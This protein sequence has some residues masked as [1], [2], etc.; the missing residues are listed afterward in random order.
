MSAEP[1][2]DLKPETLTISFGYDPATALGAAKP[3]LYATTTFTYRS[4]QQAKDIHR[5][6]FDGAPAPDGGEAFIY[7]RLNHPNLAMIERRLAVLDRGEESAV[8]GSGMAAIGG[9]MLCLAK[10]GE[11]LAYNRPTYSGTDWMLF[12]HL[13]RFGVTPIGFSDATS[14][15]SLLEACETALAKGPLS[16]IMLESPANPTAAVADIAMTAR[17]AEAIGQRTGRRPLISVDNTFLG[18]FLQTPLALGA[19]LCITS[20]TKYCA[21][22]SDLLAGG[23]SGSKALIERL[24]QQRT[25]FGSALNA[26][27]AWLL[28]RSFETL[29]L[30][31]ERACQNAQAIAQ[32]LKDHPKVAGV[33]YLGFLEGA[34][35]AV[36]DRQ[37]RGFGSTFSFVVK[38]DEAQIF[39]MLDALKVMRMAVSLGGAETLICH[40]ATTTHYAVP[41]ER[42]LAAGITDGSLRLSVGLEHVDDLIADLA[43]A[44]DRV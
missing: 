9:V 40:S 44:L 34:A 42:R 32:F 28:L 30:R 27:D 43:Q 19:D 16:L 18:P 26:H 13:P 7:A 25:F 41:A 29:H 20:L 17:V 1:D 11:T 37:C 14:E 33:T 39:R 4:A 21:G 24:K 31:T 22:H 23:V 5:A 12:E 36:V 35:R 2:P 10:P 3:P 6:F 38:G 8:F 15:A